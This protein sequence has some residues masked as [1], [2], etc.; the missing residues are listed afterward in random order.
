M[1][2]RPSLSLHVA[3]LLLLAAS[4]STTACGSSDA[5]DTTPAVSVDGTNPTSI[6]S[7]VTIDHI[8][9]NQGVQ[10]NL[11]DGGEVASVPKAPIVPLR[12]GLVRVHATNASKTTKLTLAAE[13]RVHRPGKE[14]VVL[15][16]GPR[17]LTRLE[18]SALDTTFHFELA[19]EHVEPGASLSVELRD[20]K[21]ADKTTA[22]FPLADDGP[23]SLHVET[24]A[25]TLKVKFAP[26]I[27]GA[28]GS[29]RVPP[30]D[31]A[32]LEAHRK[33]LYKMYPVTKV[34]LSVR[35]AFAWPLQVQPNGD[36]W[37]A[38]LAAVMKTRK[39]DKAPDDVYYVG[40]FNP[41]PSE[42]EYCKAGCVLGVAPT[43]FLNMS[44]SGSAVSLRAAMIVGYVS[45]R[46]HGT[47]A[48]ELA[49][50][51]ERLH[52]PCGN[53]AAIDTKYPYE[54]ASLGVWGWDVL[55]KELIGPE[56]HSDFMS[57]CGPVWV[58]D[59]TWKGIYDKMA[60]VD[61]TKSDPHSEWKSYHLGKNGALVPG[62]SIDVLP[63]KMK[64]AAQAIVLEDS[65]HRTLATI[66]G[67]YH[68]SSSIEGG[69]LVTT[70]EIPADVAARVRFTRA[71]SP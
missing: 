66:E 53:P 20:P 3:S 67:T 51:M 68:P 65:A 58:S 23:L 31:E 15:V 64:T 41:A 37:N 54:G 57:Y 56:D 39:D 26:V 12:P 50:A 22:R 1:T 45:E 59:Y 16:D 4:A 14:D 38:L 71:V 47:L 52:A 61:R 18:P 33:A 35:E 44:G 11:L 13:L 10:I 28:D 9:I 49:H 27:Y 40:V 5:A 48:Q 30:L 25:P 62:A 32:V 6:E 69:V 8:S 2:R 34:E 43:T 63:G 17:P 55:D 21:G 36:G 19:A 24:F 70:A 7:L 42:R 46:S 60:E 29:D